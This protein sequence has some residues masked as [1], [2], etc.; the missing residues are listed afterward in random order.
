LHQVELGSTDLVQLKGYGYT[1]DD[2]DWS[3]HVRPMSQLQWRRRH[4][5]CLWNSP[6]LIG[7]IFVQILSFP[8]VTIQFS[9]QPLDNKVW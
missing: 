1:V 6:V 5:Q 2:A 7:H 4:T 9:H 3:S 8:E